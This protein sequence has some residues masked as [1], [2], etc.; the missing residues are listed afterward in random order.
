[1]E[2]PVCIEWYNQS[3]HKEVRC[4]FCDYSVCRGCLQAYMLT[5]SLNPHCMNC[6]KEFNREFMDSVCYKNY[7]RKDY[8]NHREN[9]LF[10]REKSYFPETQPIVVMHCE[11]RDL[12]EQVVTL[13]EEYH[14][15]QM[16]LYRMRMRVENKDSE[17]RRAM[18]S[19][20]PTIKF[21]YTRK[22]PCDE[23]HGFLNDKWYCDLCKSQI[24]DKCNEKK[25]SEDHECNPEALETFKLIKKDTKPCPTCGTNIYKI[26]GCSQM[27]CTSCH[28]AFDWNTGR[29]ETG[30]VH[31]PHYFEF[32][33]TN[34]RIQ[35]NG[36]AH[37]DIP[38]GGCPHRDEIYRYFLGLKMAHT[39]EHKFIM[40]ITRLVLHVD[41][42]EVGDLRHTVNRN[43]TNMDLRVKYMMNEMLES[44]FKVAIQ[45]RE[46]IVQH[47]NNFIELLEMFSNVTSDFL[48]QMLVNELT[49]EQCMES[50]QNIIEYFN[51]SSLTIGKRYNKRYLRIVVGNDVVMNWY[52]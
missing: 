29:I 34:P 16:R 5:T 3:N 30:V 41:H 31:N 27:W 20:A 8:K 33:N 52:T 23:C 10:E 48:R 36:R 42:F 51:T 2:C 39:N 45:K 49:L 35:A 6:K 50:I 44:A 25:E 26:S 11:I 47:S 32:R 15:V 18:N 22:C 24:C 38:C 12:R 43:S 14:D 13:E 37:G 40:G 17:I 4:P 28:T 46:K 7:I 21:N 9:V 1:M 19:G